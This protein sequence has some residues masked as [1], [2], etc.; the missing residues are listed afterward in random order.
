MVCSH[1]TDLGSDNAREDIIYVFS[2]SQQIL[3]F[4]KFVL[5]INLF[6]R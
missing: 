6:G 3:V 1:R 4:D 5:K 2:G